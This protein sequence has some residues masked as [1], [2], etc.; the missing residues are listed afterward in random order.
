MLR[1]PFLKGNALLTGTF[2]WEDS[3]EEKIAEVGFASGDTFDFSV[4]SL[5]GNL[6]LHPKGIRGCKGEPCG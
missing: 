1:H 3:N 4:A 5:I 6:V 2:S